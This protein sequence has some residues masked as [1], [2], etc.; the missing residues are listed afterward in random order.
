MR[1]PNRLVILAMVACLGAAAQARAAE[2]PKGT[3]VLSIRSPQAPPDWALQQ[4]HLLA[5]NTR[6][7]LR[8]FRKYWDRRGYLK[9]VERW[10]I[11][12]GVDDVLEN[13]GNWPLLYA[14]GA[15]RAV[16]DAYKAV[17]EGHLKQYT[18]E[19]V[20]YAPKWGVLHKEFVTAFDWQHHSEQYSAFQQLAIADPADKKFAE[21][22]VRFA[23]FYRNEGIDGEP[24]WDAKLKLIRSAMAGSRGALLEIRPKY[25]GHKWDT[26]GKWPRMKN[27]TTVKGDWPENLYATSLATN[28]FAVTGDEKHRAWV[29]EYTRAWAA[30]A[31]TNG[32]ILPANVGLSGKIGEHW[33]GKWWGAWEGGWKMSGGMLAGFENA[34]LLSGDTKHLDAIRRQIHALLKLS[35]DDGKGN[36]HPPS[37]RT[38]KGWIGKGGFRRQLVRL[39]L[40]DF[41]QDDLKLIEDERKRS[42]RRADQFGY[43]SGYFYHMDDYAWL[44]YVLGKNP[45]FPQR[46]Y[47]SDM[48]RL[49]DR[50]RKLAADKS[51][52]WQRRSDLTHAWTPASTHALV[53]LACGGVGPLWNSAAVLTEVWHYDPARNRPG[54]PPDVAALVD[55]ITKQNVSLR[56]VNLNPSEPRTVVVRM[57]AYGQ[58]QCLTVRQGGRKIDVNASFFAVRLDPGCGGRLVLA[59]KRFANPPR[60]KLPWS[61]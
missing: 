31:R 17:F 22:I 30:R 13:C 1:L 40:S 55:S 34:M 45:Q 51:K 57:G 47:E 52:D 54:L 12:D 48:E 24:I 2:L 60:A 19:K 32:D 6:A 43:R 8:F 56:L 18:T 39:Y 9:C 29:L 44:Y 58:N 50:M 28:A 42:G 10:S 4:R 11:V 61:P 16:L 23:G 7:V 33:D 27:F 49:R 14:L 37:W 20:E 36:R 26:V 38:D 59:V 5:E 41:R 3:V 35:I 15:D 53:N 25:W 21:R 46:M